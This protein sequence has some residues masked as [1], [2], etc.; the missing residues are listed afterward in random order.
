MDNLGTRL[1]SARMSAG[2]SQAKLATLLGV[3]RGTIT[4]WENGTRAPSDEDKHRLS[5]ALNISI[6][7][8]MGETD[9]PRPATL[10][11]QK[12]P[13]SEE[14]GELAEL[15]LPSGRMIRVTQDQLDAYQAWDRKRNLDTTVAIAAA[16][17]IPLSDLVPAGQVDKCP[18]ETHRN[19]VGLL[20]A[21]AAADP[22]NVRFAARGGIRIE[23]VPENDAKLMLEAILSS[24]NLA[25]DLLAKGKGQSRDQK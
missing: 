13:A 4:R 17:G 21:L 18:T 7:Y 14:T 1:A 20:K 12:K 9:E 6:A 19:L 23:D 8:L 2:L 22:Q 15:T 25:V 3:T 16:L 24:A 11:A 5:R 10:D